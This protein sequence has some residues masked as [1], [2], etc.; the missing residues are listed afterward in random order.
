[1]FDGGGDA[2]AKLVADKDGRKLWPTTGS[3]VD[4]LHHLLTGSYI[5]GGREVEPDGISGNTWKPAKHGVDERVEAVAAIVRVWVQ[6][7][8]E[9]RS[10]IGR[11]YVENH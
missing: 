1:V 2:G 6:E 7:Y 5:V 11:G 10:V 8:D 4:R 3:F 9:G